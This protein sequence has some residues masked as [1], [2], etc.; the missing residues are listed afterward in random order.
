M[1]LEL[2][3]H[4][5]E[6]YS[7]IKFYDNPSSRRRV[8]P[9]GR[10]DGQTDMPK[11]V[12]ALCNFVKAPKN[13]F[14]AYIFQKILSTSL[15]YS[16]SSSSSVLRWIRTITVFSRAQLLSLLTQLHSSATHVIIWVEPK[17]AATLIKTIGVLDWNCYCSYSS[18]GTSQHITLNSVRQRQKHHEKIK[19]KTCFSSTSSLTNAA[20]PPPENSQPQFH[21]LVLII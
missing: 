9:R 8:V 11:Q 14:N 19:K 20:G 17:H 12:D 5:F 1:K 15:Y 3:C 7:N 16:S 18:T 13:T 21:V 2:S 10:A 4:I 6:K